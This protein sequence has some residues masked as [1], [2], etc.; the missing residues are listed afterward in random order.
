[1]KYR[2]ITTGLLAGLFL[3]LTSLYPALSL[4]APLFRLEGWQRPVGNELVHGLLLMVIVAVSM[5]VLFG[6]GAIAAWRARAR[7]VH[8]GAM[9]GGLAGLTAGLIY[10][11]GIVGPM[12]ALAA[13]AWLA[14]HRPTPEA[15]WPSLSRLEAYV[16]TL[17]TT[18]DYYLWA[19]ALA[20]ILLGLATGSM[21]GYFGRRKVYPEPATLLERVKTEYPTR[22]WFAH[23]HSPVR[24]ALIVGAAVGILYT[25]VTLSRFYIAFSREVPQLAEALRRSLP[26]GSI[27]TGSILRTLPLLTPL[28]ALGLVTFGAAVVFLLKDPPSRF[29]TRLSSVMLTGL[30]LL[31]PLVLAG[32]RIVSFHLGLEPFYMFEEVYTEPGEWNQL[33]FPPMIVP[34]LVGT[35][36][37]IALLMLLAPWALLAAAVPA[38]LLVSLAQGLVYSTIIPLF[39]LSP[40]DEAAAIERRLQRHPNELLPAIYT[41]FGRSRCG[42]ETLV[43]LA[44]RSQK[45]TPDV[46]LL[47]ASLHTLGTSREMEQQT[48]AVRQVRQVLDKHPDWRWAADFGAVYRALDEVLSAGAIYHI[49]AI[50]PLP[51]QQTSSLPPL[52][53]KGVQHVG[54]VIME[55]HKIDKVEDLASKLIFLENSLE[56]IRHA[57]RFVEGEMD[58]QEN[59][60]V[61]TTILPEKPALASALDHWQGIVIAS[62]KRLKGRAELSCELL[63]RQSTFAAQVPFCCRLV[64]SG[65][66]VAQQVRVRLLPGEDYQ[67][68][69]GEAEVIEILPP[70][71]EREVKIPLIPAE[72]ARRLR[73]AWEVTYDDAVDA[74]RTLSFADVIEFTAPE[75]AFERIF[76]IPYVTGTPLKTDDV[77]VGREDVFAFIRENLL[78]AHQNNIIILHG[79]RR[80]GKTS[81]LYRLGQAMSDTHY[82]VLIDMQ[83]KP[84]RGEADFLYSIADDITFALEEHD[85]FAELPPRSAFDEAPEFFFRSRFLRTL[86]PHLDGKNLLLMFDEFE[87]LQRR[88]EDG[89]LQPEIFQF[90][91]NLMQHE[92]RVDFIFSG[93]HKLEELGAEYWSMLFNIAV[94]KPITFLSPGEVR[95]LMAEP[96]TS[97]NL[98]Y[99]SLAVDR[100]IGV[101]AG[102]PYFTQ[103]V[104]HE[105]I[106]YYN[107]TE[108]GYV[109]VTD[110]DQ[111][112]ERIVERGEAHFK[113][114]WAESSPAEQEVL[115]GMAEML[116]SAEA[117]SANDLAAY[118]RERGCQ[119]ADNWQRALATLES[120]DILTRRSAKSQIYR[121][122]VDLI[123][124]WIDKTR[125][126]L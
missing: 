120:R 45:K 114:I 124:L 23:D 70:G 62:I 99:D 51:E 42:Y 68:A 49:L 28:G 18:G 34:G 117:V 17:M 98:E 80:T 90:L 109:T 92:E 15:I 108:H 97:S 1:M 95:R 102:H 66:N 9:A 3:T 4:V 46:A 53:V 72:G 88:V 25:L 5:P 57:Q 123:R 54:R 63:T 89:R 26:G 71:E 7:T 14:P 44:A 36:Q 122:K 61:T 77:F 107:E 16:A 37:V 22:W 74:N 13:Y 11:L 19:A 118:L 115:K 65:L 125:P 30:V 87:E 112:L 105:M 33:P 43:H 58:K 78:G 113:Y 94:Y 10:Y 64:N 93:T 73:T 41:L 75:K 59:G 84:A 121:F 67:L 86:Y 35:P 40:V 79:Q 69:N 20:F 81:V 104:L 106:V 96:V 32:V 111:V 101:T 119:S 116:V 6:F 50:R 55:F 8:E 56:A 31:A 39:R 24:V 82:G 48:Q 85:V 126:A 52:I 83:G 91:R 29:R 100:I 27:V 47:A 110:V 21:I 12:N 2:S 103:L 60:H 76:P 38:V